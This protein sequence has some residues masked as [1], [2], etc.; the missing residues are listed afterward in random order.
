MKTYVKHLSAERFRLRHQAFVQ[1]QNRQLAFEILQKQPGIAG[2][3]QGPES[4]FLFLEPEADPEH[5]CMALEERL[6]ELTHDQSPIPKQSHPTTRRNPYRK[7]ILKTYLATGITTVMLAALGFYH[8][9]KAFGWVF[10][11][12]AIEHVWVRRKAL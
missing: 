4:F 3:K 2:I 6:P 7:V 10:T 9:H 8:W 1:P 11:A 5:I 12:F